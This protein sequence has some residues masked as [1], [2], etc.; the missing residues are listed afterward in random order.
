M[1]LYTNADQFL[2][3]R[4]EFLVAMEIYKPDIV[5]IT[6]IKPKTTRYKVQESE[7]AM[8]NFDIFHNLEEDGRGLLLYVKTT[9]NASLCEIDNDFS[10]KLFVECKP[11]GDDR[12]LLG[13]I[14]R[15]SND[16]MADT[17][18]E[19]LNKLFVQISNMKA[20][21]KLIMGDFNYPQIDWDLEL[22][23]VKE[24]HI[25]SKFLQATKDSFLIQHQKLPTRFRQGQTANTLDLVFTNHEGLII[26]LKTEAALGKSDHLCLLMEL[27]LTTGTEPKSKYKNFKRTDEDKLKSE[28]GRISWKEELDSKDVNE[29]WSF[30]KTA[31]EEA[32]ETS[33]PTCTTSGRKNKNFID[34]ETLE[35]VRQKHRLYRRWKKT[36]NPDDHKEYS[37]ANT[38]AR[39]KC[40]QANIKYEKQVAEQA[41]VNPSAFYRYANSKIKSKTGIADLTKEDGS[42]TTTNTE[43]AELLN[44]FFKSVF[45]TENPG[46]LPDFEQYE[47]TSELSDFEIT[48]EE[49][50]KLLKDL[51]INKASGPDGIP[52]R[53]LSIA[54]TEL[55]VPIAI[56]FRKS[57]VSGTLPSEWKMAYVTPIFKKGN[58]SSVNNYRPV[59]LTCVVCKLMEKIVR[60]HIMEH[61]V[62]NN[63][64]SK[65]Q[66][67]FVPRRSCI[68]QLL[69]VLDSWTETLD[70][71]GSIDIVYMDYQKAFD[72]VPHRR[73]LLKLESTGVKNYVLNW[74][75]DF[76]SNRKQRV[77]INGA[78][79]QD[80]DVTSGIPQ[81]SVLGPLLFVSY[82]NDQPH[83]LKTTAKM[84]ADN[85]KLYSRSDTANGP[86]DLQSD[87]DTLQS[88]SDRW[89][90]RF[91]PQKCAVLKIGNNNE[92]DYKMTKTNTDGSQ[93][94]IILKTIESEKDLGVVI[95]NKLNFKQQIAQSTAKANKIVGL[96]RRSFDYLSEKMFI[97]LFKSLVRP[98]L[99]YGHCVWQPMEKQLCKDIENVQRRATKMLSHL[100]DLSYSET[101][102]KLKLPSL[103]HRRARGDMIETFKYMNG[104]YDTERPLFEKTTSEQLRGHPLKLKK[105]RHRLNIRANYFSHR[106]VNTWNSLPAS[107]V[108]AP[109]VDSFKR[110]LDNHWRDLPTL[111]N[112]TCQ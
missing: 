99:E 22:S 103:E 14:Y 38:K 76:L 3:K 67:G 56:L 29:A 26:D 1:C 54:A 79:S 61:F 64:I 112:P 80:A 43:K 7:L 93:S 81:G 86:L 71:G 87:L 58:K 82:I 92:S 42:K 77:I 109:S 55:S 105:Q 57:L 96:I 104:Y 23:K 84:F 88:W 45:T 106:I 20:S 94:D 49:V 18:A 78:S 13:L 27:S 39:K 35:T 46:P 102:K 91:H 111:F 50:M 51:N 28:L 98:L 12:L 2:N 90:L 62:N 89:L 9:L 74:V 108:T 41:K 17:H 52:P 75:R 101:L 63:L 107:I 72:S 4:S 73:L 68:T 66:H 83:D 32:I 37:R 95:D 6:E 47:Y 25:A 97:T 100:K 44:N 65:H 16:T 8:D 48:E 10:E 33:T 69:E 30:I 40:R 24:D 34:K 53:I 110:R 60:K 31:I 11:N 85:T 19:N 21:H 15:S 59:S 70:E 5:G 36:G